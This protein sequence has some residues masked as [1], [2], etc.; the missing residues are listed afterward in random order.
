MVISSVVVRPVVVRVVL[1]VLVRVVQIRG[2]V[3]IVHQP[4]VLVGMS[5]LARERRIVRVVVMPI[6][7]PVHVV[8]LDRLVNMRVPM[9]LRQMQIDANGK[10]RRCS[11]RPAGPRAAA[12]RNR[13]RRAQE[14]CHREH[15]AGARSPDRTLRQQV[16]P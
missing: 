2:V 4:S 12:H 14:R 7:V 11:D 16:Q 13:D 3:V 9:A 8:M 15:R 5:V 10:Q 1:V 6:V